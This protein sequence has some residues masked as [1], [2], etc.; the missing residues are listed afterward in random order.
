MFAGSTT[1]NRGL[2]RMAAGVLDAFA[3]PERIVGEDHVA[4]AGQVRGPPMI[5][6]PGLAIRRMTERRQNRRAASRPAGQIQVGRDVEPRPALECQLLDSIAFSL[7]GARDARVEWSTLE[8]PSQHLPELSDHSLL[9][10]QNSLSRRNR[11]D[12]AVTP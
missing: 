8:G 3:L 11:L 5:A 4:L 6:R 9:P 2:A 7:D 1:L 10:V 12:Q